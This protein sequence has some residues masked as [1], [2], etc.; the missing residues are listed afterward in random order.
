MKLKNQKGFTL[1]EL[2]LVI[3]ILGILAVAALPQFIDVAT[4]AAVSSR[5][6]VVGS[7]REGVQMWR[8]QDL[9]NNGPPGTYPATLDGAVAGA[10]SATNLLFGTIVQGGISDAQWSKVDGTNYTFSSGAVTTNYVYDPA[11][12]TFLEQ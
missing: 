4:D 11:G 3:T 8:A 5:E 2:V 12:G 1:I 10:A 6:G 7:V 9:V